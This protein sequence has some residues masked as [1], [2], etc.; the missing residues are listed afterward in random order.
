VKILAKDER[1]GAASSD[2]QLPDA[3]AGRVA[4]GLKIFLERTSSSSVRQGR[5]QRWPVSQD[6]ILAPAVSF[7]TACL[8]GTAPRA[9]QKFLTES[10]WDDLS[11]DLSTRLAFALTPTLH[12]QQNVTKVVARSSR[13]IAQNGER[14]L[15]PDNDITL[16]E[17]TI[18]FPDLLKTAAQLIS[19]W[20]DAQRELFARLL[21]DR[22]DICRVFLRARQPFRVTHIRARLSD[23]HDGAK[24]A[25]MIEFVNRR[26]VIYKPR[27][28]GGEELWFEAL[29]WLNRNGLRVSFRVPKMLSRRS[30][31]WMEFLQTKG[32]E[33]PTAVR[34][35][36]FRWG[37]QAAL[38]QILGATDLHRENWLAVGAQPI[39]VDAELIGDAEP[40]SFRGTSNSKHRQSLPAL[41][42]TG[43][44]PFT[45]RDHAGFYR[46]IA[47]LDAT[48]RK[49]PPPNCWPR[50]G[51][52]AQEP[53]RY[54]NDLVRGFEVVA[55]VFGSPR[56]AQRFFREVV[57][58][59]AGQDQRVLLR[60]TAQYARLLSESF[61]AR[62]MISA[63]DRWRHLVRE[64]CAS[65]AN[66]RV[67]LAEA[68]SL[69]RCDIPKFTRRRSALPISWKNF[70]AAIAELKSSSRL[71]RSRVVLGARHRRA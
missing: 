56:T 7:A 22:A 9:A 66:R 68:R 6:Q 27:L 5:R 12:V 60:A 34:L 62:N 55:E 23:P 24:T 38:A 47:P 49:A 59:T 63:G 35:F 57:L 58:Q 33:S 15:A 3:K 17:T 41:L 2:A 31:F 40:T 70:S 1:N 16:L 11:R 69:L 50:Y 45:S 36:Y 67:G 43:L 25:T 32:C 19:A 14:R 44:L 52:V 42:Q 65:A 8:R 13:P 18:E 46:G 26:R 53:S 48:I 37:A 20:I 28:S 71:L 64:C 51:R 29:R 39:L 4:R 61:D 10:A 21:R 30:Y 54:V